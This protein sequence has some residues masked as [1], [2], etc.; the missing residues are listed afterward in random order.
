MSGISEEEIERRLKNLGRLEEV[1]EG[2]SR[3]FEETLSRLSS[4]SPAVKKG[5][6]LESSN[7]AV[8]AGFALV[9]GLGA[10]IFGNSNTSIGPN[11]G[12]YSSASSTD[13]NSEVLVS[14]GNALKYT[15]SKVPV[16]NSSTDYSEEVL[17][18]Q[19]PFKPSNN[20]GIISRLDVGMKSC[21]LE[22]GLEENVSLID[23]A[24]FE[25]KSAFAIW[26][27]IDEHTWQVFIVD[28]NCSGLAEVL[29]DENL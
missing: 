22:L 11:S 10:F 4:E 15:N 19:L 13:N 1:P 16:F 6:W 25:S 23:K 5:S 14:G 2:V 8:A 18:S 29:I 28:E 12:T 17:V 3:R 9:F 27:A 24:F 21:V 7:W 20:F 26:S